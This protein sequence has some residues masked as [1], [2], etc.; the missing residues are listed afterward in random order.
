MNPFKNVW[1]KTSCFAPFL[2]QISKST[3]KTP[4]FSK[5]PSN[6]ISFRNLIPPFK[7]KHIPKCIFTKPNRFFT[8]PSDE[9]SSSQES[10]ITE[11]IKKLLAHDRVTIARTMTLSNPQTQKSTS[12]PNITN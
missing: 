9:R 1:R 8:S 4:S 7:Q 6:S 10:E 5:Q 2:S 3:H 12:T 11:Q